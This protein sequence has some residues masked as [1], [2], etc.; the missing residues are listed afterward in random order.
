MDS[1]PWDNAEEMASKAFELYEE[2]LMTQALKQLEDAIDINPE[3]S[4][5]FF[6]A[7][8]T[9]DAMN[10]FKGAI[11]AYEHA[12]ELKPDD[13][14][15]LNSL[16][17]DYT[18][19]G[20][21]D[22][23]LT[24]FEIVQKLYPDFEPCYCN[25]IITYT[26]M[27]Q[28]ELAEEMFYSAQQINPDCPICFYNIGNS[29]FSR[30]KYK[31]A[32]W[33]WE[34]TSELEPTH[35]QINYR[36]AQAYWAS[37]NRH[38]ARI[39]FLEELRN[40]PGDTDTILE[41]GI[42]LLECGDKEAAREKFN[43]IL[44]FE[45]DSANATFYLGELALKEGDKDRATTFFA[46]ASKRDPMMS[47]PRHRLAQLSLENG[48]NEQA[49]KYLISELDLDIEDADV[50]LSVG[51]MLMQLKDYDSATDCF[52]RIVDVDTSNHQAFYKLGMSLAIQ[53]QFEGALQFFEHA[54]RLGNT[55]PELFANTAY[56]YLDSRQTDLAARTIKHALEIDPAN[57]CFIRLS[58]M[59]NNSKTVEKTADRFLLVFQK[60][61]L[62]T[63]KYKCRLRNFLNLWK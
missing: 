34:K 22:Q 41:F 8:L 17:I 48:C 24:T 36:I 59:I 19:I 10:Q 1:N 30:Q 55:T 40:N 46:R 62:F 38:L 37:G 6:N 49:H 52:L 14:E 21:Y 51:S 61:R 27:D 58:R 39:H 12:S 45:P 50:L 26:E 60:A 20:H 3:N 33:C 25:R 9:L 42:F 54:I 11:S 29:L 31:K 57:K 43:R 4:D 23:A 28:H 7:G 53:Q 13:P 15:I 5:L 2:G 16:A 44:E 32:I 18:R 47:G 35:P 56:L 63:A